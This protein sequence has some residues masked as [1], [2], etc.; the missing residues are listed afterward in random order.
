[1]LTAQTVSRNLWFAK[2]H[3]RSRDASFPFTPTLSRG[4][5]ENRFPIWSLPTGSDFSPEGRGSSLSRGERA[6]VRGNKILAKLARE[7]IPRFRGSK[8][9]ISFRKTLSR[10]LLGLSLSTAIAP[11]QDSSEPL[12]RLS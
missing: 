2:C 9:Q 7:M 12:P 1:M 10:L 4:E 6:R 8:R 5:R 3:L 11:A